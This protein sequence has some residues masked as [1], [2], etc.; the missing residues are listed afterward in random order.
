MHLIDFIVASV[1]ARVDLAFATETQPSSATVTIQFRDHY[2]VINPRIRR[3]GT[4][5]TLL[6]D[7]VG[8]LP[9]LGPLPPAPITLTYD[10]GVLSHGT[11]VGAF[12]MDGHLYNSEE[13]KVAEDSFEAE[14]SL[15]TEVAE[16]VTLT[17][18]VDFKDP[19]V[20]ITDQGEPRIE[21]NLI[22]INATANRVEF[23]APPSG[24]PQILEYD[25][26]ALAPGR[27]QIVYTIN[28]SF[29]ARAGFVVPTVCEPLP[30]LAEIRSG[31]DEDQWYSKVALALTPGQ[32]VL[33]WG[34]VRQSG[35]EFHV[36]ITVICQDSLILPVPV[37][38]GYFSGCFV[39]CEDKV[40]TF[41][42]TG[43][44]PH[45]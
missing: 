32:Q 7:S 20:I 25:L 36:D 10:L 11:Y 34:S 44:F 45:L 35:N 38:H 26:G 22:S 8:P 9:I 4:L 15:T 23:F 39:D 42:A 30:H 19:F 29:G 31:E 1:P 2:R 41:A 24:D 16:T 12:V 37:D 6:A 33:D 43:M 13:F 5:I 17:A 21:G 3:V 14:I 18:K 28:R 27:Y 40:R